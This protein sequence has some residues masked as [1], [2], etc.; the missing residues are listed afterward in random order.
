M[1]DI[2]SIEPSVIQQS[3][4]GK[5]I[6]LAGMPKI[7]KSEFCAQSPKTL[8]LDFENG[9]NFH[10]NVMKVSITKWSDVKLVVRQL[11]KVE[12][13]EKYENVAIDTLNEAW[14]LCTNFICAQNGVQKLGDIPY[15]RGYK[16]RDD[17]FSSILRKIITLNYGLIVTCH[18]K[19]RTIGS[20]NDIDIVS[21]APDLDKRC[22][23]IING[24]VDIIGIIT[25]T[26]NEA[27]ES[28]RWL[29]TKAT[30][31]I[32]AGTRMKNL[33]AKIPFGYKYLEEAVNEAIAESQ[34]Q[35]ATVVDKVQ[36]NEKELTFS[37]IRSEAAE[38]WKKITTSGA[39]QEENEYKANTI[40][41]K[42]EIIFGHPVV[43]SEILEDQKDLMYLLVLDMR[44]IAASL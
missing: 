15:G 17:E 7:G 3:L 21:V 29:M 13:R 25:Q 33:K 43:L 1:I 20:Q 23:P 39:T 12:A 9:Y 19:E 14:E 10:P 38:L 5:T 24:L 37:E 41:K 4:S 11:E 36:S 2:L 34:K 40:L 6:L 28:E 42:A 44:E 16:D 30:P 18:I 27:G 22:L 31:T 32:T 26:W 35:G 8:I